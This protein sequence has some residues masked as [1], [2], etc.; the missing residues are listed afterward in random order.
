M[1]TIAYLQTRLGNG[2]VVLTRRTIR[3]GR[4]EAYVTTVSR[5]TT[6]T[7]SLESH[8]N[9]GGTEAMR[10]HDEICRRWVDE[11]LYR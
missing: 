11:E 8:Y 4:H 7:P 9:A 1:D 6:P 5:E 10:C 2:L 3:R